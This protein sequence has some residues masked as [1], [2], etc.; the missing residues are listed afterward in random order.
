MDVTRVRLI[1][2]TA[3]AWFNAQLPAQSAESVARAPMPTVA[4]IHWLGMNQL[5]HE[6]N[7]AH[8]MTI[9]NLPESARL[10][11]HAVRQR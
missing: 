8:F 10:E 1:L 9:W 3:V 7:A 4:R 5:S 6:T 11:A 2:F